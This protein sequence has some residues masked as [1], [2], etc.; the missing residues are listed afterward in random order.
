MNKQELIAAVA[1]KTGMAKAT[2]ERAVEALTSIIA[3]ELAGGG[4]VK[5]VG[6]GTF[7]SKRHEARKGRNPQTGETVK[8]AARV[9]AHFTAGAVLKEAVASGTAPAKAK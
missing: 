3:A 5:L 8:I 7:S 2:T 9:K 4:E 6:F 1:A